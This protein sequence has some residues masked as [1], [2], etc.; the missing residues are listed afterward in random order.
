MGLPAMF[1]D[2]LQSDTYVVGLIRDS[3]RCVS[4]PDQMWF[5]CDGLGPNLVSPRNRP[6]N[7]GQPLGNLW[8]TPK[9]TGLA[10]GNFSGS[11]S[12]KSAPLGPPPSLNLVGHRELGVVLAAVPQAPLNAAEPT[13]EAAEIEHAP[14]DMHR[15]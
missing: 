5:G 2:A 8:T 9:L 13:D 14:H 12:S 4:C 11:V 15:T 7:F 1:G 10:G 6:S 3:G